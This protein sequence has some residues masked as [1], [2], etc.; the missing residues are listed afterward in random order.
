MC[1]LSKRKQGI[2]LETPSGPDSSHTLKQLNARRR[3]IRLLRRGIRSTTRMPPPTASK[4]LLAN[5]G[6]LLEDT[7]ASS[8][9]EQNVKCE[10]NQS[11]DLPTFARDCKSLFSLFPRSLSLSAESKLGLFDPISSSNSLRLSPSLV[12]VVVF[13]SET[14]ERRTRSGRGVKGALAAASVN[15]GRSFLELE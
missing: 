7:D 14:L 2:Q 1:E 5:R 15:L 6:R 10:R 8:A 4:L 11:S 13:V 3:T 9:R 12:S